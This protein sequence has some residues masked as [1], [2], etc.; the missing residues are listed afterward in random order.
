VFA[1]PQHA[2]RSKLACE[3]CRNLVHNFNAST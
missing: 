3:V 2:L 1:F